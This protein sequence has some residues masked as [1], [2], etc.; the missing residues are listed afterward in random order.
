ML[1]DSLPEIETLLENASTQSAA[2]LAQAIH[3]LA[4]AV[5][6]QRRGRAA[7]VTC[8]GAWGFVAAQRLLTPHRLNTGFGAAEVAA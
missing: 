6:A 5:A 4:G 2:S 3:R 8:V 1:L 7:F